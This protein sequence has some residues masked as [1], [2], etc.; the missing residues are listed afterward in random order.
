[1]DFD[2]RKSLNCMFVNSQTKLLLKFSSSSNSTSKAQLFCPFFR[3]MSRRPQALERSI[4][5][6]ECA[7]RREGGGGREGEMQ[8][9][10]AEVARETGF[11][12]DG[13]SWVHLT[14]VCSF[15]PDQRILAEFQSV[16]TT[17]SQRSNIPTQRLGEARSFPRGYIYRKLE[18]QFPEPQAQLACLSPSLA[19]PGDCGS[20]HFL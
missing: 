6:K 14:C 11:L 1:M 2:N 19:A 4:L 16:R 20:I 18:L 9:H 17:R 15:S 3:H 8:L 7:G 10:V 5:P 12:K 13:V